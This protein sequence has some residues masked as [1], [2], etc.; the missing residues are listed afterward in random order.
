MPGGRSLIIDSKAT[1]DSAVEYHAA[2]TA[3]EKNAFRE[4]L[5][6][7]V[8]KHVE[9]ISSAEYQLSVPNSFPTVLMYIP[10]E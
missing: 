1:I 7:S 4:R 2:V 10:L 3:D 6:D 8:R 5:V 9:E